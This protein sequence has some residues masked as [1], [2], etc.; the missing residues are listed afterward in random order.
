MTRTSPTV[1]VVIPTYNHCEDLLKPCVESIM[2]YSSVRFVKQLIIVANGCTDGTRR[3]VEELQRE[4]AFDVVLVW[5]DEPLGY[6]VAVNRGIEKVTS[7]YVVLMNNDVVL[8]EQELDAWVTYLLCPF[9]EQASVGISGPVKFSWRCGGSTLEAMAFWLVL[10]K[11]SLFDEIGFLDPIFSPGMGEDGDFCA[12]TVAKGYKLVSVPV[13]VTGDFD[14]GIKNYAFPV[15]HKGNGTFADDVKLKDEVIKR[16]DLILARRYGKVKT[17]IIIPTYNHF[18]DA[19]FPCVNAVFEYTNLDDKELIVVANGCTDETKEYLEKVFEGNEP[20][21]R[22]VWFDEPVGVVRAYNAGIEIALGR[23]IVLLDNDSFLQPQARDEWIKLLEKPFLEDELVG[24]AGPFANDYEHLGLMLHSGCAMYDAELLR[25]LGGFDEI[26]N[27]GYLSDVD[28]TARISSA[29][30]KV[31]EVPEY[32]RNKRYENGVFAINFPVVHTGQ[33]QTMNKTAD[34]QV[35]RKNRAILYHRYGHQ[36]VKYTIIIPTYNH[37]EDLLKPCVE[38][39]FKYTDMTQVQLIV[40]ANG[41]TDGT[42]EYLTSLDAAVTAIYFD[43]PIGYT[44]AVNMGL[45]VARGDYIVLLNN[46]TELLPQSENQW[47]QMLEQPFSDPSVGLT[48]PLML[49]DDY[50]DFDVLIFFCAM[51][52]REVFDKIGDLDEIFSPGGGEDIDFTVRASRAGYRA[53][54]VGPTEFS[55][56]KNTN[57]GNVPIWHKDNKTFREIPEYTNYIVK[58]NGLINAKRYNKNIKLNLGAGG[59]N[60]P[61]YLSVDLYDKRAQVKMDITKLDFDD[62]SVTEILASHVFEHLNP[63]HSL[64]ILKD[65]NR[66]LRPGGK[67]I[68]EMPNIEELCK[69][70]VT[71]STGERYG[72]LNAIYGSVNTTGEGGP[73]NITSPHLFGWWPQSLHDHLTNAGFVDIQF[74]DEQIPHPE[75]NLRVEARKPRRAGVKKLDHEWLKSLEPATYYEIFRDN[76]YA[77]DRDE[78]RGATVIDVGANL[79]LFALRCVELGAAEVIAVEAQATIYYLG[80]INNVKDYPQVQPLHKAIYHLDDQILTIPNDHVGSKVV[81]D[82]RG[83]NVETLRLQTLI[84]RYN[85]KTDNMVLKLDCEG[86]EFNIIMTAERETLRLFKSIHLEL[87]QGTNENPE[88]QDNNVIRERLTSFGFERVHHGVVWSYPESG[89][90]VDFG[91][92]VEK[93]VRRD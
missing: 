62:S 78:I 86:S 65:W 5:S 36:P 63:Y 60:C 14:E 80:L 46:D 64:D 58:R 4:V 93:W 61:G 45:R 42:R 72:I 57:V 34:V 28:V 25:K 35:I 37:C 1:S 24:A 66:V 23:R 82:G 91:I 44:R 17:S 52:K 79:G 73:D 69:R 83:E 75:D 19:F 21:L 26:Y 7:E 38:S 12:K 56:E 70:F 50:A 13:D 33:V 55:P 9:E 49:H 39:L 22:Y 92:H 29:G 15:W 68:M 54:A 16:N 85:L 41:C 3:Y 77:L 84:D 18:D 87:H 32:Q 20:Q 81:T 59:V 51:I 31:R 6:P 8:L 2:K 71:A 74:M 67:L 89:P 48:G 40:V 11:R 43:E 88:W 10:M 90:P 76:G 30:Y 53:V 27:P 47:L